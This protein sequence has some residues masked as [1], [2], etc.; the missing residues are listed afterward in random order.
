M[1]IKR[2]HLMKSVLVT[3]TTAFTGDPQRSACSAVT[4]RRREDLLGAGKP[5]LSARRVGGASEWHALRLGATGGACGHPARG[6][7]GGGMMASRRHAT[8]GSRWR[9]Q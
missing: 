4:K 8:L 2:M 7:L 3:G 6:G 9:Q 5:A 1:S